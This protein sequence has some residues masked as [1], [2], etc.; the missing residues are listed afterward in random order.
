M[1][2]GQMAIFRDEVTIKDFEGQIV[3]PKIDHVTWDAEASESGAF[4]H[5]PKKLPRPTVIRNIIDKHV[6]ADNICF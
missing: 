5:M 6:S 2:D 1:E 3:T 4:Y